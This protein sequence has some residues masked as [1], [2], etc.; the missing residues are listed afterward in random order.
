MPRHVNGIHWPNLG[1][2]QGWPEA[3]KLGGPQGCVVMLDLS[4]R[5][6]P[7]IRALGGPEVLVG[8]RMYPEVGHPNGHW[9]IIAPDAWADECFRRLQTQQPAVLDDPFV[10][11]SPANEQDLAIEGHEYAAKPG[12]DGVEQWV[13]EEIWRW[14]LGWLRRMRQIAPGIACRLG[15]APLAGGHDIPGWPPD[16][17]YQ[18]PEFRA[19]A[20]EADCVWIHAYADKAWGDV[21][22]R[23]GY[24]YGLRPLRP[25]GYREEVQGKPPVGGMPDPGGVVVQYPA[26]SYLLSETGTGRHSDLSVT[27]QTLEQMRAL[28]DQYSRS[29]RCVGAT[30][31][32]WNSG[33]EHHGNRIQPNEG[34]WRGLQNMQRFAAAVWP[35]KKGNNVPEYTLGFKSYY[36]A[37]SAEVGPAVSGLS[38][39]DH[40]N[41]WQYSRNGLLFWHKAGNQIHF[42]PKA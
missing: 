21:P 40:G 5:D 29:G 41:A 1:H 32:I 31:F 34:L 10:C 23:D 9:N 17:E 13:Y 6:Y 33:P 14:Q 19:L 39:D 26:Q 37:H 27:A 38:Y 25:R 7:N 24:W 30:P 22:E 42:F 18:L 20:E 4:L 35:P 28:Y 3:L 15:T 11:L 36:E 2:E 16:Y 12:R 8:V